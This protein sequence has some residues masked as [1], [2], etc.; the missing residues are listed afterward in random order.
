VLFVIVDV[1]CMGI[2]MGVPVFNIL[3]GFVVGWYIVR[4]ISTDSREVNDILQR[5][6][7]IAAFTS[8]VTMAGMIIIWGPSAAMLNGPNA[9]L[10]N[11]G[12]PQ[13][14]FEP[15]ASFIGWLFLMIAISPFLQLLT[16]IFGG[17]LT[18]LSMKRKSEP[19]RVASGL[20]PHNPVP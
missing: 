18:L 14:L 16:T 6:L 19:G 8:G 13:I 9:N 7:R 20:Q 5:L 17:H 10:A 15:R 12:I 1:F 3:L 2:G 11:F 4:W